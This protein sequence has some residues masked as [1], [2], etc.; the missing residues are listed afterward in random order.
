M[1]G[2]SYQQ[3]LYPYI[4]FE[5]PILTENSPCRVL[6]YLWSWLAN[7]RTEA[8]RWHHCRRIFRGH[9]PYISGWT[10]HLS[11][12]KI[13][14]D[15]YEIPWNHYEIPWNH[16]KI[17]W[18]HYEIPWNHYEIP[19]NHYKIPWDHYE[20][21]WDHHETPAIDTETCRLILPLQ[22]HGTPPVLQR[23]LKK[24]VATCRAVG[25]SSRDQ[26][27]TIVTYSYRLL[28]TRWGPQDS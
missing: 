13:P 3:I 27:M 10:L 8:S 18:D 9:Q 1:F 24:A 26:Q 6:R 21:P 7:P 22:R 2:M 12:Y 11:H 23:F 28:Y 20:I 16:Y 14:W 17:P 15:H 25:I 5:Y 4:A 19:W